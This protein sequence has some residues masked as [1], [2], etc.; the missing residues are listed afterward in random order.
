[1]T[2]RETVRAILLSVLGLTLLPSTLPA[3]ETG[4][5]VVVRGA[6]SEN[7]YIA[8][9]TVDVLADIDRDLVVAGGTVN[10]RQRVKADVL[11]AGGSVSLTGRVGDDVR[12]AGGTVTIGGD[13]GGDVVAAG[14][15][16]TLAPEAVVGGRTWLAGGKVAMA[17][18]IAREL[19]V[20][21]ADV[22]ISGEVHGDVRIAARTIEILPTARITGDLAYTSLRPARIDPGARIL[23]TVTYTRSDIAERAGRIGRIV[24]A[25]A[26]AA[27]LA[28]L[29]VAGVVLLLLLPGFTRSAA[30]TI[31]SAFWA[32]LG[33]GLAVLVATPVVA[34][35]LMVTIIGIPLGLATLALYAVSLLLGY[36]TAAVFLGDLGARWLGRGPDLSLGGRALALILALV[37]LALARLVPVV[38]GI[39]GPLALVVGLGACARQAYRHWSGTRLVD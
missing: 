4:S 2:R 5:T 32:S 30:R 16:V 20:A 24:W 39:V 8:G 13:V 11:V 10:V 9:G 33:V 38:G 25:L 29:I 15:T 7:T 36:L 28:G 23:G 22:S 12:A 6:R 19:R 31:A 21:A 34:G 3:Q 17:G 1:M 14:G 35:L 37:A 27:L 18:R 26:R